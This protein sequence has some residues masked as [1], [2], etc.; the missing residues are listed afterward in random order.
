M[1]LR[2]SAA[3]NITIETTIPM[4]AA[5]QTAAPM[6]AGGRVKAGFRQGRAWLMCMGAALLALSAVTAQ[7]QRRMPAPP[8]TGEK[9]AL[10]DLTGYWVAI[11]DQDWRWRMLTAPVGDT[12]SIPVNAQGRQVARA[13]D[14]KKDVADGQQCKAYGAAG[15]MRVPERL[16]VHWVDDMTLQIDTDAGQQTRLL[17]FNAGTP[18]AT[19]SLQGYSVASWYKEPQKAGFGPPFGGAVPGKG[20]SLKVITTDMTPGYLRSNGVPY[21]GNARMIEYFDR[22][23]DEGITYLVL[24]SVV[25]DPAYLS[26]QYVTSYEYKLEPDGSK[27]NPQPCKVSPPRSTELPTN[28]FG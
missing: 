12:S 1:L 17:H 10:I 16:H 20:G 23:E 22:V 26:D 18:P 9:G 21:S 3:Q 27:W 2:H 11:V 15:I 25:Q 28:P 13:W 14:W 8:P 4:R 7:A 5:K 19:P 24:T 6:G